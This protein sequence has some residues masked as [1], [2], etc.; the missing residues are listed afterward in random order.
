MPSPFRNVTIVALAVILLG[1][2]LGLFAQ[3]SQSAPTTSSQDKQLCN[4]AGKVVRT[5]TN[6]PLP[7]ARVVLRSEDDRS[8]DPHFGITDVQGQFSIEGIRSGRYE[9]YVEHNGFLRKSYGEDDGGNSSAVLDLKPAQQMTDLIFRLQRCGAI[10]GRV[11]DEDGDPAERVTVE[12]LQRKT[13]RGKVS[14]WT[15]GQTET[16]DLGEYRVF[17]LGPGRYVIRAHPRGGSGLAI[18]GSLLEDSIL[19]SAGGY[20]PTYYPNALEISRASTI[21]LK[22]GDDISGVDLSLQ[23]QRT[24]K[25]R[26]RV[27]NSVTDHPGGR[28]QVGLVPEDIDSSMVEE[29]RFANTNLVTGDFEIKD[30]PTGRYTLFAAWRDGEN[31]FV[32]SEPIEVVNSNL[33]SVRIVIP[34]GAEL[35]GKVVIEG[36]VAA[37]AEMGVRL[38]PRDSRQLGSSRD[39]SIKADGSFLLTGIADGLYEINVWSECDG[40]YLKAVKANG[41]DILDRG[42]QVSS[43]SAPSP[44]ELV[45][46]SNTGMIDGTVTREDGLPASGA[47]VILV[48]DHLRRSRFSR[49]YREKSTDQYGHFVIKNVAPGKYHAYS[50]QSIDY[51]NSTDPEFLK[52]FEQQA[53]AVSIGE[54]EKKSLQLSLISAPSTPQ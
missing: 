33:D 7:K 15:S 30:V 45:Y 51:D 21:E 22:A 4:I 34:R 44:I 36:K 53:Q 35:R 16:N 10:S 23:S 27:F 14:T 11:L 39:G 41:E 3:Q 17:D 54:N 19:K 42:L 52:G 46:S 6:E 13:S 9:M 1:S 40:C 29:P 18:G 50:W 26:G 32:G 31:E 47:T 5:D 43:G 28:T 2:G 37:P 20:V 25:I 12:A 38:D 8:A 48:P 49:D 24:F